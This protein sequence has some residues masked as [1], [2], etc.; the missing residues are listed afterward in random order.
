MRRAKAWVALA[1]VV[2]ALLGGAAVLATSGSDAKRAPHVATS[3]EGGGSPA[4]TIAMPTPADIQH[5]IEGL[6]TQMQQA[7]GTTGR[8]L[9]K[10]EVE[11]QLRA[12]LSQLGIKY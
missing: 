6:T 1:V 12:Q 9:T 10:E 2:V 11:A 7:A 4:T 3:S 8:P 5:L